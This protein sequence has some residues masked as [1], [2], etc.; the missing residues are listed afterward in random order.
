MSQLTGISLVDVE[1]MIAVY[2]VGMLVVVLLKTAPL[3]C[4]WNHPF[5]CH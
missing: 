1:I 4:H 5:H 3:H 2:R